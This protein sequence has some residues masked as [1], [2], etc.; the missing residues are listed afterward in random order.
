MQYH[1]RSPRALS[2]P[3]QYFFEHVLFEEGSVECVYIVNEFLEIFQGNLGRGR[4]TPQVLEETIE[5]VGPEMN[6]DIV[7]LRY[8]FEQRWN[9][10]CQ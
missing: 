3:A 8:V 10:R 6:N 9:A 4:G 7:F 2:Q 5:A 1:A